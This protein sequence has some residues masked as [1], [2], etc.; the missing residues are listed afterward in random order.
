MFLVALGKNNEA[1]KT[2]AYAV[3]RNVFQ[4]GRELS[5]LQR[6]L[7]RLGEPFRR[8]P[9]C[10]GGPLLV[11]NR[12]VSSSVGQGARLFNG[13]ALSGHPASPL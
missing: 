10:V 13:L 12:R 9:M 3:T 5:F 11:N 1:F 7:G 4:L 8:V 6:I 2:L